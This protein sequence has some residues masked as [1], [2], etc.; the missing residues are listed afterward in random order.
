MTSGA[1]KSCFIA[2]TADCVENGAKYDMI[3]VF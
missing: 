2:K 1:K 3:L